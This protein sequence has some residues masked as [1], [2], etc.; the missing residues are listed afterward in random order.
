[1]LLMPDRQ[2]IDNLRKSWP[3][4]QP[5]FHVFRLI[6]VIIWAISARQACF[7]TRSAFP[8]AR[9]AISSVRSAFP[10]NTGP[11]GN[12][13]SPIGILPKHWPDRQPSS[14]W[15]DR[16]SPQPDRHSSEV[17]ARSTNSLWMARSGL[18][19]ASRSAILLGWRSAI[20]CLT[21][22]WICKSD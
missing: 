18:F 6:S 16:Q 5:S 17:V 13:L 1:M 11:I 10:R 9:S 8:S 3:D 4:R 21:H 14:S 20:G 22:K 15:P 2:S 19:S 7:H 12:P